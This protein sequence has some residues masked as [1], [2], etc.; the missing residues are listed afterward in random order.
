MNFKMFKLSDCENVS[1]SRY[2]RLTYSISERKE[3]VK[4][5]CHSNHKLKIYQ[6][7]CWHGDCSSVNIRVAW[8]ILTALWADVYTRVERTLIPPKGPT[9]SRFISQW[10]E[11]RV[12]LNLISLGKSLSKSSKHFRYQKT[13]SKPKLATVMTL[14][15]ESYRLGLFLWAR[16]IGLVRFPKSRLATLSFVVSMPVD[17][18]NWACPV[19]EISVFVTEFSETKIKNL[20]IL[21][22]TLLTL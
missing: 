1:L 5:H 13:A 7:F 8:K 19:T 11:G 16:S 18:K 10:K 22:L 17:M 6:T 3:I 21:I 4:T 20:L 15:W 14:L 9:H 12:S 2:W